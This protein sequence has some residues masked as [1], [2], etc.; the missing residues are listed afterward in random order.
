[1]GTF[2]ILLLAIVAKQNQAQFRYFSNICPSL[3]RSLSNMGTCGIYR[4]T[5]GDLKISA[6]RSLQARAEKLATRGNK[7]S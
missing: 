5:Q 3:V 6:L 2:D 7:K 4:N 1:M